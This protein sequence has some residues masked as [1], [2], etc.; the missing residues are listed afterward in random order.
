MQFKNED[1]TYPNV[2]EPLLNPM[3][4]VLQPAKRTTIWVKSQIYT[5]NEATGIL[6][7]SPLPENDEDLL[8]C[9]ALS[10]TQNNKHM[11][12]ISNFLDHPY[13]LKKET[14]MANLS[15][16]TPKQ[17]K[18]IRP[19]TPTSVRHLLNKN[20]DDAILYI[21]SLLQTSKTN[22]INETYWFPTPQNPGNE[23]EHSPIHTQIL[24]ELRELE[25]LE[26]LNPLED[27]NSRD[28]FLSNFD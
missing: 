10:S 21:T 28:Q 13:T 25:Q 27:T 1:R 8:I 20:H 7:P 12:Q 24:N 11:V 14:H 15:I 4:S 2:I 26:Q 9:P 6:Q 22:E 23:S 17:T 3:K 16:L 18:H 19:V 5:E